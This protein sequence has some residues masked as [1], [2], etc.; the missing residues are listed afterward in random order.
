VH[1][2][3]FLAA[4]L[5]AEAQTAGQRHRV[6]FL[7]AA[8]PGGQAEAVLRETPLGRA[9]G[10]SGDR[11]TQAMTRRMSLVL[12]AVG[13]TL[14]LS[15]QAQQAGRVYHLAIAYPAG[16]V[17]EMTEPILLQELGRLGYGEGRI[18]VIRSGNRS[19]GVPSRGW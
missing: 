10:G 14:P 1:I 7:N 19:T 18:L 11:V 16:A 13:I 5:A 15:A 3:A 6:G 2:A 12:L 9:A 17:E 8:A 4:P